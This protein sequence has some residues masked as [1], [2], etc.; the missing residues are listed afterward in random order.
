MFLASAGVISDAPSIND[1][2]WNVLGFLLSIVGTVAIIV[3]LIT[4]TR[5]FLASGNTDSAEKSKKALVAIG[6]G[7]VI[8]FG[9]L[10]LMYQLAR[11]LV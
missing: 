2:L 4:A 8:V 1:I 5:Y 3:L 11:F 6:L 9:A 7:M 10:I